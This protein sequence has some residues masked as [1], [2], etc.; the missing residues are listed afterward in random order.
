[1][2]RYLKYNIRNRDCYYELFQNESESDTDTDRDSDNK[3]V[4]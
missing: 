4:V 1:M 3:I 2:F